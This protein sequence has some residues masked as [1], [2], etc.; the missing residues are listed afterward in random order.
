MAKKQ[1][2]E[3]D[4]GK[5]LSFF[6]QK[7][8]PKFMSPAVVVTLL[9]LIPFLFS[10]GL[11][12]VPS[13]LPITD[14]WAESSVYSNIRADLISNINLKYPNLPESQKQV[15]LEEQYAE[16]LKA[17]G[18]QINSYVKEVSQH[19]KNAMKNDNGSTYLLAID[20]YTW[21]RRAG[22]VLKT[23]HPWDE[24]RDGKPIDNHMIAPLGTEFRPILHTYFIAYW[25]RFMGLFG[26]KDLM[27]TA[28]FVPILIAALSVIP[29]FF[30]GKRFAGNL[31]GFVAAMI[32]AVSAPF[33]T[34]TA[35]GFVDT[36]AYNVLF[37]LLISWLFIEG[38]ERK[39]SAQKLIFAALSGFLIG[40]YSMLWEWWY[41]FNLLAIVAIGFIGF[42]LVKWVLKKQAD[43]I[44]H[45]VYAILAFFAS[46]AL[47][48]SL[49]IGA[50]AFIDGIIKRP[51]AY[52]NLKA[53]AT[54]KIWPNVI[55]TVAE[56]NAL[57]VA[58]VINTFDGPLFFLLALWG[59]YLVA[60]KLDKLS[61][62][63]K[64]LVAGGCIWLLIATLMLRPDS[65]M[66]FLALISLPFIARYAQALISNR[67]INIEFSLLTLIWFA[68]TFFASV[69]GVRFTL[70]LVP[71]YALGFG[72]M[73]GKLFGIAVRFMKSTLQ[74]EE[75]VSKLIVTAAILLVLI[76]PVRASYATAVN[77]IP[78]M[79]DAW[80]DALNKINHEAAPDAI[81]NSWWDFGHW[82][83]AIG[84]RAVTFD[85]ASQNTPMAH[86]IGLSLL[87]SDEKLAVGIL[88][89]LDCGSNTAFEVLDAE[90]KDE[91]KSVQLLYD[92]IA[93][94]RQSAEQVLKQAGISAQTIAKTLEYT[95][96]EPPENYYITSD[97]MIGK[98]GVWAHFGSW[99]FKRAS[100]YRDTKKLQSAKGISLLEQKYNFS[101]DDAKR[102][103]YEIQ[104]TDAEYWIAPWPGYIDSLR[105]CQNQ[106]KDRYICAHVLNKQTLYFEVDT[107]NNTAHITTQTG[108]LYPDTLVIPEG[109]SYLVK[110]LGTTAGFSIALIPSGEGRLS[111]L[112]LDPKLATST[113]NKLFF[114][115]GH[116]M[117]CFELFDR[118]TQFTG[119]NIYVWKV[120]WS[121]QQNQ[122]RI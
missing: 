120:D 26:L 116:G 12:M 33:L 119:G 64:Y 80:F 51:L 92:I 81:I 20:P 68:F 41:S 86:W 88:R 90:L 98:S 35:G 24:L 6:K 103:Y 47:F 114:Y 43:S 2:I 42:H 91:P 32:V 89:M 100:I 4:F 45:N 29:A 71:V 25:H 82:F 99:D 66:I 59:I 76:A 65:P 96:C 48:V 46:S 57:S 121:C 1:D 94:D 10:F 70:L 108:K 27:Q 18:P 40:L 13:S 117:E 22:N 101:P 11:R 31:G 9:I 75:P 72:I 52:Y 110:E 63:E 105:N 7:K 38:M 78:S 62:H 111:S 109:D 83:K 37:P 3:F 39:N 30:L 102:I 19:F 23:G 58:K 21:Y 56:Q 16:Y 87:T 49:F 60:F 97:D 54:I 107:A 53:V 93:E 36:D 122:T 17:N 104:N 115:G 44:K 95:H 67:E 15:L 84:N 34:R 8:K 112:L 106:A 69:R 55:T 14:Q 50:S 113:F 61:K 77:Q 85:G 118:Q 73:M 28:F 5:V 74:I 79:N